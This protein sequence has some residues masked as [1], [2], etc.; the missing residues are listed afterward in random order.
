MSD[1]LAL[2]RTS[3]TTPNGEPLPVSGERSFHV[4]SVLRGLVA[5][6]GPLRPT[7]VLL[8]IFAG[9]RVEHGTHFFLHGLDP[10]GDLDP[11]CPVPLL[12]IGRRM[13][14]MVGAVHA[15]DRRGK[16]RE[17]KLFPPCVADV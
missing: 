9:R 6:L 15:H 2:R 4:C 10:V 13:A 11:F 8:D 1:W 14:I 3:A 12:H 16:A 5:S 7:G 17:A